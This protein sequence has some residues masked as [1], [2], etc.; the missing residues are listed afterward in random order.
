MSFPITLIKLIA[1]YVPTPVQLVEHELQTKGLPTMQVDFRR[2][3]VYFAKMLPIVNYGTS[4][5]VPEHVANMRAGI[6]ELKRRHVKM[7]SDLMAFHLSK[8]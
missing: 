6:N 4:T 1:E 3:K 2:Q 5:D 8:V 7:R